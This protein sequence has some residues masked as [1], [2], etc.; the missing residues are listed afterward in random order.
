MNAMMI[1]SLEEVCAI[2][3]RKRN[4]EY[5][6]LSPLIGTKYDGT[7]KLHF[8]Q[9]LYMRVEQDVSCLSRAAH[10]QCVVVKM[11]LIINPIE[12]YK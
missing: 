1:L 8:T 9:L 2:N 11:W 5:C 12:L 4:S 10:V 7:L 3:D 6:R